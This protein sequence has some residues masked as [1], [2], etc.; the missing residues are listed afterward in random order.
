MA[1]PFLGAS[2]CDFDHDTGFDIDRGQLLHV[3]GHRVHIDDTL[4]NPHL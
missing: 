1:R 2:I 4:V 3:L